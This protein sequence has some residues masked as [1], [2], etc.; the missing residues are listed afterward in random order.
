[1]GNSDSR[2]EFRGLVETILD[3][4]DAASA[5]ALGEKHPLWER[6]WSVES[7]ERDV[8]EFIQPDDVRKM[9]DSKEGF[10]RLE[11]LLHQ[12]VMQLERALGEDSLST[13]MYPRVL[14][15]I[16]VVTRVLPFILERFA[17]PYVYSMFWRSPSG[18]GQASGETEENQAETASTAKLEAEGEGAG[19]QTTDSMSLDTNKRESQSLAQRLLRCIGRLAFFPG[20]TLPSS[21]QKPDETV[22]A[23]PTD[24]EA[25]LFDNMQR[26]IIWSAGI[27]KSQESGRGVVFRG[28]NR[29]RHE[30]LKLLLVCQSGILYSTPSQCEPEQDPWIRFVSLSD[31]GEGLPFACELFCS[32]INVVC[33]H[34]SGVWGIPYGDAIISGA[35][36]DRFADLCLHNLLIFLEVNSWANLYRRLLGDISSPR[37]FAFLYEN[38]VRLLNTV[39]RAQNTY[40]PGSQ[41]GIDSYQEVLVLLWKIFDSNKAFIDYVL[42]HG[43]VGKLMQPISY[44]LWR[45][46]KRATD[47]GL[48]HICTFVA[49]LLS[50]ERSFGV[51]L[52]HECK[53][54]PYLEGGPR[55]SNISHADLL[56]VVLHKVIADG[57][58]RLQSLYN[59]FFTIL[60]NIS[61]YIKSFSH[62]ASTRLVSLFKR[63]AS[64]RF[65]WRAENNYQ[66]V[67]F[68]LDL[69]NNVIQ[70]QF[71]GNARLIY[72]LVLSQDSISDLANLTFSPEATTAATSGDASAHDATT[73]EAS[74]SHFMPTSEWFASWKAKMPINTLLRAIDILVP[75]IE[76]LADEGRES[77]TS[78]SS[79]TIGLLDERKVLDF[80]RE[81]TLVGLLPVP[82]PIVIR[83]YQAN[84][85]TTLW[86]TTYTWGVIF[87]R[88]Q[89]VPLWDGRAIKLFA[90]N[91]V[92]Q[93]P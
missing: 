10:A 14:N 6:F 25:S 24:D 13:V 41:K 87:L 65:L 29:H 26:N 55:M 83:R 66:Y 79:S 71:E 92:S 12:A 15:A 28:L 42:R 38:L 34:N 3:I 73:A 61:P 43:D 20:F 51:A 11:T 36:D 57:D 90:I 47:V 9:M 82:H 76:A 18:L 81:T 84:Q 46:R 2:A 21:V 67:F 4:D 7:S 59:C 23:E 37:E 93:A 91:L 52:N 40:L 63:V 88:N 49:L 85:Y 45:G 16:R 33:D 19:N 54:I 68:M 74:A 22:N 64:P 30:V 35:E 58:A 89:Q 39:L 75:Q 27:G 69:F 60:S 86:F 44:F 62:V 48:I 17:E 53:D 77:S 78:S 50:G 80:L 8:F 70:Y 1:M 5:G 32:L 72:T 31:V 56:V